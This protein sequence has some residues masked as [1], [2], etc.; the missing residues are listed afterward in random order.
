MT[1]NAAECDHGV[2]DIELTT[3]R[4]GTHADGCDW[5]R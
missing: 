3:W 4:A 5:D 2:E 1:G